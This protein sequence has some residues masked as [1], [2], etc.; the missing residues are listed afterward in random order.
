MYHEYDRP[1]LKEVARDRI[2][3]ANKPVAKIVPFK[4]NA[5]CQMTGFMPNINVPDDFDD[6]MSDEIE[7]LFGGL[8]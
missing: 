5:D 6:M 7:A 8:E 1:R 3:K 2:A 4:G